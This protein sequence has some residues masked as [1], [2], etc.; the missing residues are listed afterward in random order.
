M[1]SAGII[2]GVL[3]ALTALLTIGY[4]AVDALLPLPRFLFYENIVYAVAYAL[5]GYGLARNRRVAP[6]YAAVAS[7][8]AGRV[9]R[10]VV[11][12]RG[13]L[14]PLALQHIP[15]LLLLVTAAILAVVLA[16]LEERQG[17]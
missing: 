8:N 12:P 4:V 13:G 15:L 10:S 9:S 6:L 1:R 16:Y 11:N 17:L 3:L 2:R 5:L 14:E 7:F